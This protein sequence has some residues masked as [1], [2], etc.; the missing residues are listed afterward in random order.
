MAAIPRERARY[1]R[2]SAVAPPPYDDAVLHYDAADR[3]LALLSRLAGKLQ[4]V[5]HKICQIH[6]INSLPADKIILV[7]IRV[8][9]N[10]YRLKKLKR[11]RPLNIRF[12]AGGGFAAAIRC[13]QP[14]LPGYKN[15]V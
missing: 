13:L 12:S 10:Q 1:A 7:L 6:C 2:F 4:S 8:T 15:A 11:L 14:A 9:T 3:H 5:M